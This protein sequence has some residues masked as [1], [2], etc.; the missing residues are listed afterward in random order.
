MVSRGWL[1]VDYAEYQKYIAERPNDNDAA[2]LE[3]YESQ[4]K[5]LKEGMWAEEMSAALRAFSTR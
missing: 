5:Q 1:K 3:F 2:P 4:A